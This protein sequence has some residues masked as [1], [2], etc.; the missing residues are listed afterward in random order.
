[1]P[2]YCNNV[3]SLLKQAR[4]LVMPSLTE[5]LPITL[6]EAMALETPVLVSEVGEM[7]KLLGYGEGGRITNSIEPTDLADAIMTELKNTRSG[8]NIKWS[9]QAVARHYSAEAMANNY[10]SLYNSVMERRS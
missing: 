1:M 5:G 10:L 9:A 4:L 7:P 8:K 6:I 2:G 3:P